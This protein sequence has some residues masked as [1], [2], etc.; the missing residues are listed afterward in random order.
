M[1]PTFRFLPLQAVGVVL[2][3]VAL[4]V[5]LLAARRVGRWRSLENYSLRLDTSGVYLLVRHPQALSL[6]L[7][8]LAVGLT[9]LSQPYLLGLPLWL[10]YWVAYTFIEEHFELLPAYGD[11]YRRY[12]GETPRL[13]PTPRSWRAYFSA[14]PP[15]KGLGELRRRSRRA[16]RRRRS[17]R[18]L[19]EPPRPSQDAPGGRLKR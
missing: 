18:T 2:G 5:Y 17:R 16:S 15:V 6:S 8:A 12:R 1:G 3:I 19:V 14:N 7:A 4:V 10:G 9:F 13:F 11:E